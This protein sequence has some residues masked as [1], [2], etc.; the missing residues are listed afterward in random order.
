MAMARGRGR[1]DARGSSLLEEMR[2]MLKHKLKCNQVSCGNGVFS[3]VS[4]FRCVAVDKQQVHDD[5]RHNVRPTRVGLQLGGI[6]GGIT[7]QII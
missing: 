5:Y 6:S 7:A 1:Q 2:E 3:P 4:Q